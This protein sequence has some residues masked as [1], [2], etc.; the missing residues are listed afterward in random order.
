MARSIYGTPVHGRA[1]GTQISA[2]LN[3]SMDNGSPLTFLTMDITIDPGLYVYGEPIPEGFIPLSIDVAPLE[4]LRVG[5]P[6]FPPPT[7]HHMEGLD[8]LFFIYKGGLSISIPLTFIAEDDDTALKVKV[9][10]QACGEMGC[11]MP[12]VV[13]L[14]LPVRSERLA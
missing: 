3:S 6:V 5:T 11:C 12:Q 7:P 13:E 14:H 1:E 8:E 10:Y 4:G 9:R 2:R